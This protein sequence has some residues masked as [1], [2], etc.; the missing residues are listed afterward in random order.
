MNKKLLAQIKDSLSNI[1]YEKYWVVLPL[2]ALYG[3]KVEKPYWT[4][5]KVKNHYEYMNSEPYKKVEHPVYG[6]EVP[7]GVL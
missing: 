4:D 5:E 7:E 6:Y 3:H 1:K 2:I